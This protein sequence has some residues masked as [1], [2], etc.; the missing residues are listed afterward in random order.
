MR[1]GVA[2]GWPFRYTTCC[3]ELIVTRGSSES[4][5]SGESDWTFFFLIALSSEGVEDTDDPT[6]KMKL[7]LFSS[8]DELGSYPLRR[9]ARRSAAAFSSGDLSSSKMLSSS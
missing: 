7:E 3:V 2:V 1:I 6:P 9:L 4:L 5:E 8:S